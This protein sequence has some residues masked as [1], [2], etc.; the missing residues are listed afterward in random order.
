MKKP[1]ASLQQVDIG[2]DPFKK[3]YMESR[4]KMESEQDAIGRNLTSTFWNGLKLLID[5]RRLVNIAVRGEVRCQP[6]NELVLMSDGTWKK[7]QDVQKEDIV[8]SP[9]SQGFTYEKVEYTHDD[10]Q[11]VYDIVDSRG[12]TLYRC[13]GNH[14]IPWEEYCTHH[15][16]WIS[17][18]TSANELYLKSLKSKNISK[19]KIHLCGNKGSRITTTSEI[20]FDKKSDPDVDPYLLGLWLGDGHFSSRQLYTKEGW[21]NKSREAGITTADIETLDYILQTG[22]VT[23]IKNKKNTSAKTLRFCTQSKFVI[24]LIK[25]DLEGTNSSTK[26]IPNCCKT[27]SLEFRRKLLAGLLDSDGS[28]EKT[29][30]SYTTNSIYLAR[31]IQEIVTTCGGFSSQIRQR[32]KTCT[33]SKTRAKTTCFQQTISFN[34]YNIPIL[35]ERKKKALSNLSKYTKK[36]ASKRNI[37]KKVFGLIP[38]VPEKVYGF[39]IS[40]NSKQYITTRGIITHNTGKSTVVIKIAWEINKYMES[41]G[42]AKIDIR[43]MW[44]FIFSDQ[45]EFLRFINDGTR[46]VALAID[47]FN[48]MAKTGLNATTEEALFE[49]YS[50]VFAAQ[51]QHR[52]TASPDII[53]DKNATLILDVI[54]K[55]EKLNITRCKLIYRD[56]ITKVMKTIGHIDIHTGD[57]IKNWLESARDIIETRAGAQNPQEVAL[58]K[59]LEE[60]DFYV[61]YQLKKYRRMDLIKKEGVRDVRELEY[62]GIILNVVAELE[63]HA[64][65]EKIDRDL[66]VLTVDEVRRR[67]KRIYTMLVLNEI[68]TKASGLLNIYSK[69]NKLTARLYNNKKE[70]NSEQQIIIKHAIQNLKDMLENRLIEQKKLAALYKQYVNIQ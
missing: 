43:K 70:P 53:T 52:I 3:L 56:I 62:A 46:N 12:N 14:L 1:L 67:E 39:G 11:M 60:E 45:T 13:G 69:I 61:H 23:C 50:D 55:D 16:K 5:H 34:N 58:I 57:L 41:I 4:D 48:S 63:E 40:G 28:C 26:F 29:S 17:K 21:S 65:I 20:S 31:D 38:V 15:K 59:R 47:E 51:Y 42:L 24:W 25:N 18:L 66:M 49:Y 19:N 6:A 10:I 32:T 37:N 36:T 2:L 35:I 68:G 7:V 9:N 33:N 44:K 27:T 54:G 22:Y 64:K 8:I 30:I